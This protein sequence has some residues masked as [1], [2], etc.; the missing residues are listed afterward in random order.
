MF[1]S[2]Y[3][4]LRFKSFLFSVMLLAVSLASFQ[5]HAANSSD[6]KIPSQVRQAIQAQLSK[7]MAGTDQPEVKIE[8][9]P[10]QNL[11]QVT[12]GPMVVY[13]SGNGQY[14]F[15]GKII[16]LA[17]R[18]N[19]TDLARQKAVKA[20]LAK[21]PESSMIIYPAKGQQKHVITVFTDIDCPYCHKLHQEIPKLNAAG[22]TVRYL[23]YP[24][25]GIGSK[26]YQ[27]AVSVWCASDRNQ[28]MND[29]MQGK[30][31]S[32]NCQ[33]TVADQ[34]QLAQVF[35]VSGT[36]TIILEDG[37]VIP[38]YIPTEKLIQLLN[39]SQR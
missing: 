26:S 14:L 6:A 30:I 39:S 25:A 17:H 20:T 34:Y 28:A 11:Y 19:L 18:V 22:I 27:K 10:I 12:L 8:A 7:I 33:N 16:D 36:P 37:R 23:S 9:T 2:L 32:K 31:T 1:F 13:M 29:A 4:A 38:G 15:T 35:N 5:A 21:V 24:R 3:P